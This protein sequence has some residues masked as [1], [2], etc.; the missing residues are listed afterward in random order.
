M[1]DHDPNVLTTTTLHSPL[2]SG[3]PLLFAPILTVDS[4]AFGCQSCRTPVTRDAFRL[5][6]ERGGMKSTRKGLREDALYK[7][8]Y[9]R[10]ACS[11][12]EE[13]LKRENDPDEVYAVRTCPNCGKQWKELP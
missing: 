10:I 13:T 5:Q 12:C 6:A 7:D 1:C 11:E 8:N 3:R 2:T 9:E 4:D